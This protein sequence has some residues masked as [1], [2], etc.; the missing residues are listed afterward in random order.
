MTD[1]QT[2]LVVTAV[3]N[4]SEQE[5]MQ[6]YLT[7]AMPLLMEAGG[8]LIKRL[9]VQSAITG[10]PPYV[11]VLVMDFPDR[12]KLESM[13]ASEAYAALL[14]ARDKGFASVDICLTSEM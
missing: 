8:Q 6:T 13:F 4:P 5:S 9:K 2:T 14:P 7:G 10:K 11:M 12:E 3:P 1:N